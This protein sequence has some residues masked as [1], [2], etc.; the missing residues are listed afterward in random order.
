M[1]DGQVQDDAIAR[2]RVDDV[3]LVG[4]V[5]EHDL[6]LDPGTRPRHACDRQREPVDV[7][8]VDDQAEVQGP[9]AVRR[10]R[11]RP[12]GRARLEPLD[13][14]GLEAARLF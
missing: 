12:D 2:A 13:P 6:P 10:A 4:V 5:E 9:A 11:V 3:V 1:V 14:R 8:R 7:G